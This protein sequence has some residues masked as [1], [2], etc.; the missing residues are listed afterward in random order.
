MFLSV[1]EISRQHV[2][3]H[4]P[5]IDLCVPEFVN[6]SLKLLIFH[7]SGTPYVKVSKVHL[8]RKEESSLI[9]NI[10]Y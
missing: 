3:Q 7:G 5:E 1:P 4:V 10:E 8:L 9:H 2:R 6:M